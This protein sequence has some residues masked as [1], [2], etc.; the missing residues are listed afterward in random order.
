[1]IAV[2]FKETIT[3]ADIDEI[4]D[5]FEAKLKSSEIV[6]L[7]IEVGDSV[8]ETFEGVIEQVKKGFSVILPNLCRIQKAVIVTDKSWLQTAADIKNK[9][10]SIEIKSFP[11]DEKD[12]AYEWINSFEADVE[13]IER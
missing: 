2:R 4:A 8:G 10:F 13:I 6:N 11:L 1:M 9:L 12:E 3:A 5:I 7:Y